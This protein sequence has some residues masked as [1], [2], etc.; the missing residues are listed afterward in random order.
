MSRTVEGTIQQAVAH[1]YDSLLHRVAQGAAKEV[2]DIPGGE[3]LSAADEDERWSYRNPALTVDQLPMIASELAQRIAA[4]YQ[5]AQKPLPD[6]QTMT[7]LVASQITRI[8]TNG[9][10]REL[11]SRGFP[12]PEEQVRRA[13]SLRRRNEKRPDTQPEDVTRSGSSPAAPDSVMGREEMPTPSPDERPAAVR[14]LA[15]G[16]GY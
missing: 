4:S 10:R 13:E 6:P 15:T 2:G 9:Y 14:A 3:K 7:N 16:G 11:V 1:E 8:W 12:L 5:Q